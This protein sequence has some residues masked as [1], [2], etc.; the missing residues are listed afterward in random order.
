MHD[1]PLLT[2]RMERR[3]FFKISAI[4]GA[5]ATLDACGNP[6]HQLIRFI[7]EEDLVPGVATWK[8]SLCTLCPAGCGL[9]VRV[10]QGDAEV[11]RNGKLG[12]LRMGLAK[13]L[14]G[15]PHHPVNHGKLCARGQAG[16]Q[17]TYHPD[18]VRNPLKRS[19]PRGSGEF[20]EIGWDDAIKELVSQLGVLGSRK[21]AGSLAFFTRP[22]RGQRRLLI[23]RFLKA[24]GAPPPVAFELFDEA[25]LRHAN[26]LSF[27]H[28][29]LPTLDLARAGYV[30]S[31]G[32]DFLGTWNSPVAQAIGYGE[33][34]QGRPGLRGKFV[35]VEPRMSQTG[36]NADEWVPA[37]PGSE[38]VLALGLAHVILGE[39]LRGKQAAGYAGSLIAGWPQALPDYTPEQVEKRT[40]VPAATVARLAREM[41][42]HGPA[43]A[44]IGGAPLAQTN[45]LASALAVNAL[46]ELLGSVGTAGGVLFT[47]QPTE[48]GS[49]ASQGPPDVAQ[50]TF[51]ALTAFAQ[52]I[53]LERPHAPKALLLYDTNPVFAT[54]PDAH[55]RAALEKVPFIA[56]FGSFIDETS[57]L[58]D[59]V[60]PDHSPLESWLYDVPESGTLAA[61]TTVAPPA[62][63][64]L[65]NT[66]AMPDVLLDVAHQLGGP[67]AAALPWKTY[68]E[69]LQAAFADVEK[70]AGA[71]SGDIWKKAQADGWWSPGAATPSNGKGGA[72]AS[73]GKAAHPPVA[74]TE[75]QFDGSPQDFPFHL[76]PFASTML[77]DGSLA[78]LPW[79]QES[80]DPLATAMWGTWVEI[81]PQ[82]AE[83][84]GIR[85]GDLVE[86]AS[87]HG[88][89]Q[90]PALLSPG[91]APDVVA[92]PVG[93][94][95]ENFG[96]YASH[97]GANPIAILS[98]TVE[99]ETGALAWAA[100]RVKISR[101]GE[102]K[103]ILFAGGMRENP[104]EQEPR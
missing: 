88:K 77:Y 5:A 76:L 84:L 9:T 61:V 51:T 69:M 99:P 44:I 63:L 71:K 102:G 33:F 70:K 80:P 94:G 41:A 100:T 4:T 22:L 24:L 58:A 7:P 52:E 89:I 3:D 66:R 101:I 55:V 18:R 19:G 6:E 92:M 65:H 20:Q 79:M 43:V 39:K 87:Q 35:Q 48:N 25:V 56:S 97:R 31:F 34:R 12:L 13:K 68:D 78:H 67:V 50:G 82:A 17:L 10:M 30:I 2:F 38:G 42:S 45:G 40:G 59:L 11:V 54:P 85:Q 8:P 26:L 1:V 14:E 37:R 74:L 53:L 86:I 73:G 15:N 32:A 96:R 60:L 98:P 75:P 27:G 95:H 16:L 90:A 21:D 47:P 29:Q 91:I 57:V 46:N 72:P 103:L 49:A 64:P 93:Q 23:E 62:M 28:A 104:V 83:R 36:A 81:N